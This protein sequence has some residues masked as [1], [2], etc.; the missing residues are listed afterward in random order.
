MNTDTSSKQLKIG[1][2]ISKNR[3]E[4]APGA[5][6]LGTEDGY[7]SRELIEWTRRMAK[8]G[9]GIVTVGMSFVNPVPAELSGFVL[10][11]NKDKVVIGLSKLVEVIHRYGAKASIELVY[12][13]FV[14]PE[15]PTG[16]FSQEDISKIRNETSIN[17]KIKVTL[18]ADLTQADIN[19]IINNYVEA[20]ERCLRAGMDMVLIHGAHEMF[21]SQF[22][23]PKSNTR[24]DQYGG[25]VENRSRFV[26]ELL[27]AIRTK[28][29][30][31]LA[32]EYR[33]S[34]EELTPEGTKLNDTLEFARIIQDKIDLLHVS[35][36]TLGDDQIVG[37]VMQPTYYE[38]GINVHYAAE[39]KKVLDIPVATVGSINM[40]LA[41]EI[42]ADN[43]ADIV[44][45][46]R[47]FIADPDAVKKTKDDQKDTIRPCVRCNTC[48]NRP[49]YFFLPVRCAVN[50]IAGREVEFLKEPMPLR[51]KKVVVIGGGPSGME[52]A[53]TAAD[54]GH[55]VIIFEKNAQ[56]GGDLIMAS[57]APF[58]AD[59]RT[60]LE[61]AVRMTTTHSNITVKLETEATPEN[62]K[63]EFPDAIVIGV[64]SKPNL[65]RIPGADKENV[66]WVG[67]VDLGRVQVGNTVVI[68]GG[69]L[70]GCE[71]ALHLA[72]QGKKVTIVEMIT[73]E[74]MVANAPIISMVTLISLLKKNKVNILTE[75]KL[76]E[77]TATTAVIIDKNSEK[78]ELPCDTVVLSLGVTPRKEVVELFEDL[79]NEVYVVGDCNTSR[80]SL[81]TAT[82]TGFDAAM[83]I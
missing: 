23:S 82:T 69:G 43:K 4:V 15:K 22:L 73:L 64:G 13:D 65:P 39:F 76:D 9:A 27:A 59:M 26:N 60:Y 32:I 29:G 53:R 28:L 46:L 79:V 7:V 66:V 11:L 42:I 2:I 47:T 72:Q 70:T 38:R 61:W 12:M 5:N 35:A 77:I 51:K 62:I 34:A 41:E 55:E 8:G 33:V 25:T 16:E 45:M 19:R 50:P 37:Y 20:A 30:H 71:T 74:E 18:P 67:D 36:G 54:R 68:A 78:T 49:H 3:I 1:N 21:I 83:D 14:A 58:K 17:D 6:L 57:A 10:D 44:A 48:I 24:T 52:A 63:A 40:D 31:Q 56:L 75:M 80:G 81:W